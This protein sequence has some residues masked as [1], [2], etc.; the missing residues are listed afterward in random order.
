MV[1]T[2]RAACGKG[3]QDP[4]APYERGGRRAGAATKMRP[5]PAGPVSGSRRC[6]GRWGYFVGDPLVAVLSPVREKERDLW[7]RL[8]PMISA[9][10]LTDTRVIRTVAFFSRKGGSSWTSKRPRTWGVRCAGS[11]V[12]YVARRVAV[13]DD[14]EG[15]A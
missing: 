13:P 10:R 3:R 15:D 2:I 1:K 8:R 14:S 5:S 11:G 4:A 7:I 9:A 6:S 12:A